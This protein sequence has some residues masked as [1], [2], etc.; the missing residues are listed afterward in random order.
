MYFLI[1]ACTL[2]YFMSSIN[3]KVFTLLFNPRA[4]IYLKREKKEEKKKVKT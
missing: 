3:L 4:I 2:K 1:F